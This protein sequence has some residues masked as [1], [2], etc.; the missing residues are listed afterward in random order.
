MMVSK[1][2]RDS[3]G[4]VSP[5]MK[6]ADAPRSS[7][8]AS[9]RRLGRCE[10]QLLRIPLQPPLPR[11]HRYRTRR[12]AIAAPRGLQRQGGEDGLRVTDV[13]GCGCGVCGFALGN[14]ISLLGHTRFLPSVR[15]QRSG[16]PPIRRGPSPVDTAAREGQALRCPPTATEIGG[17]FRGA[18]PAT[19][20]QEGARPGERAHNGGAPR[21]VAGTSCRAPWT[22][23]TG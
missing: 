17:L 9:A 3:R 23:L 22:L 4:R 11:A 12:R 8:C 5:T 10:L 19:A 18:A 6:R 7:A 20:C 1:S 21:Q 14:A 15:I 16:T 13:P 2:S